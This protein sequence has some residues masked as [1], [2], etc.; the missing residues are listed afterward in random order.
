MRDLSCM[1]IREGSMGGLISAICRKYRRLA[2]AQANIH[3]AN[4]GTLRGIHAHA[5][6]LLD[7]PDFGPVPDEVTP[8]GVLETR[9]KRGAAPIRPDSPV[10]TFSLSGRDRLLPDRSGSNA[11]LLVV[12]ICVLSAIGR[13]PALPG[14]SVRET[15][16]SQ[17]R[18]SPG[19]STA[20]SPR[21]RSAECALATSMS[22]SGF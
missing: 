11:L 18:V 1:C 13:S 17:A 21:P 15:Q 3:P 9:S 16:R 19:T 12:L 22:I 6:D 14:H 7:G 5:P 2:R 8:S 10:G 20:I 4:S